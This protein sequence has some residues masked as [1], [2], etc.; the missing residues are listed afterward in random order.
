MG[1]QINLPYS[2]G[3]TSNYKTFQT[4]GGYNVRAFW[5]AEEISHTDTDATVVFT[6][7]MYYSSSTALWTNQSNLQFSVEALDPDSGESLAHSGNIN[8]PNLPASSKYTT[9][10]ATLV[11]PRKADGTIK[12]KPKFWCTYTTTSYLPKQ[13]SFGSALTWVNDYLAATTVLPTTTPTVYLGANKVKEIYVGGA[14]VKEIYKGNTK[15]L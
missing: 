9:Y 11:I 4:N 7:N 15:V 6:L 1:V 12:F 14:K 5:V 3:N 13:S 10:Q 2:Y 8:M